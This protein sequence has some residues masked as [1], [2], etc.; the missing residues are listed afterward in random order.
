M[1]YKIQETEGLIIPKIKLRKIKGQQYP[2]QEEQILTPKSFQ[3]KSAITTRQKPDS[4]L[5]SEKLTPYEIE[6]L[7]QSK[8]ES[9]AY[10]QKAF[11]H[12]KK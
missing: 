12:L 4:S 7:R 8:K 1:K 6:Q 9:S 5:V 11:A 3:K 10:F 2:V